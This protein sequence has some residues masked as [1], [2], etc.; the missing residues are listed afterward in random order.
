[1][2]KGKIIKSDNITVEQSDK[3]ELNLGLSSSAEMKILTDHHKIV[4]D[5]WSDLHRRSIYVQFISI[6]TIRLRDDLNHDINVGFPKIDFF[7]IC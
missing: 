4:N 1:M 2:L 5:M 7:F 6:C 3:M